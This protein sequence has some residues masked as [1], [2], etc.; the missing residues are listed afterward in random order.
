[1]KDIIVLLTVDGRR[2][3]EKGVACKGDKEKVTYRVDQSYRLTSS[4]NEKQ[5]SMFGTG[6]GWSDGLLCMRGG[7]LLL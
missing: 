4:D 3:D 6:S 2:G 1:M 5:F 7:V